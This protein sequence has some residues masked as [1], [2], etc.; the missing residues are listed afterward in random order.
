MLRVEGDNH[1]SGLIGTPRISTRVK[2]PGCDNRSHFVVEDC[3]PD[4]W[5]EFLFIL[6]E[7]A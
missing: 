7:E 1:R 4:I 5:E 3:L 2:V 6:R